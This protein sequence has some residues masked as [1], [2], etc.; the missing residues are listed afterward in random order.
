MAP[1]EH[2]LHEQYHVPFQSSDMSWAWQGSSSDSHCAH[3]DY[4]ITCHCCSKAQVSAGFHCVKGQY[5]VLKESLG[6]KADLVVQGL[7]SKPGLP[8]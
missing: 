5:C 8:R 2:A 3:I 4:S 6:L 1:G 7:Q